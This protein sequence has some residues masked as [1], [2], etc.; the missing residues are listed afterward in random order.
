MCWC[1]P[2][3]LYGESTSLCLLTD[4]A[5]QGPPWRGLHSFEGSVHHPCHGPST[6]GLRTEVVCQLSDSL[7]GDPESLPNLG[8]GIARLGE[9]VSEDSSLL[10][11]LKNSGN[12]S[13]S[14]HSASIP[15]H[16]LS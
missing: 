7:P 10:R 2:D 12:S 5:A 15:L 16:T 13:V 14:T 3:I 11:I 8:K 1:P 9:H 6:S 4:C